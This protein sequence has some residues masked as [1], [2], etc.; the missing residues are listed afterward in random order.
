MEQ[1]LKLQ[2]L[3]AGYV[4]LVVLALLIVT[5]VALGVE[6]SNSS[7][8]LSIIGDNSFTLS[9][10]STQ[11]SEPLSVRVVDPHGVAVSGLT[12]TF[13]TDFLACV[14]LDPNCSVPAELVYGHFSS[15][16][17]GMDVITDENGIATAP[18]PY[19]GGSEPGVYQVAAGV[20][21]SESGANAAFYKQGDIDLVIRYTINQTFSAT[22]AL[23]GYMSGSWYDPSQSG[24]GFQIELT[25][26][27]NA[28]SGKPI[29]VATWYVYTPDGKGQTWVYAQGDYD[30]TSSTVTLPA[31]LLTGAKFPN[32]FNSNDL[33]QTPWGTLTFSFTD[34]NT[35]VVS[36][37]SLLSGYG[38][39][40]MPISRLTHVRGTSCP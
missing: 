15:G 4:T 37:N 3:L 28:S 12:V 16:L 14:P 2:R 33:K 32:N 18:Q 27:I 34:C 7:G 31:V 22:Q 39:G 17:N 5:R 9:A 13:L 26:E 35:G 6:V 25:S 20:F 10:P 29:M 11:L 1:R 40:T 24:H 8:N 30:P 21:S 19:I 36:W 38:S 23:D